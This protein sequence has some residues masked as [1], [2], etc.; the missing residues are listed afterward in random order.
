[1]SFVGL[2][3]MGATSEEEY[4][5]PGTGLLDGSCMC[6]EKQHELPR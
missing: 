2:E 5:N 3:T 4:S 1:M 6:G